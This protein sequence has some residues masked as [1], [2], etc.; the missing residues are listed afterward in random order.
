M[1]RR[2]VGDDVVGATT[3][4]GRH[5]NE[6]QMDAIR[7]LAVSSALI[8]TVACGSSSPPASPSP[9]PSAD[10]ASS[11]TI[12]I[13]AKVLGSRAFN[14][15]EVSLAVGA[16]VTWVNADAVSHTSTSDSF[17]WNSGSIAPGPAVLGDVPDRRHV[18]LPLLDSSRDGGNRG[19]ALTGRGTTEFPVGHRD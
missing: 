19:G 12:P 4:G 11:V 9:V 15:G 14:P 8:A 16:T 5:I 7:M 10:G 13:G 1:S 3:R 2:E 18:P 17:G 6:S